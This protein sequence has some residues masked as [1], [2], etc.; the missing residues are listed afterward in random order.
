MTLE[1]SAWLAT[2]AAFLIAAAVFFSD[3]RHGYSMLAAL[4]AL[5]ASVNLTPPPGAGDD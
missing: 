5:A 4:L 1:R 2:I 3:G